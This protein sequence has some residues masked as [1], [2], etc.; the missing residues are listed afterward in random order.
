VGFQLVVAGFLF[1]ALV[2]GGGEFVGAG[3]VRVQD[4]GQQSDQFVVAVAVTVGDVVFDD[5]DQVRDL[6]TGPVER[7]RDVVQAR[8]VGVGAGGGQGVSDG[9]CN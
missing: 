5:A 1:P 4:G 9:L 7:V 8:Q 6:F 3:L 2:V